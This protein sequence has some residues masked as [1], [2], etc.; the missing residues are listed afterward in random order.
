MI[1]AEWLDYDTTAEMADAVVGDVGFVIAAALETRGEALI[2]LPGG[3]SPAPILERLAAA[4]IDWRERDD[5]PYRRPPGPA[6]NS[7]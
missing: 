1:E 5:H 3:K 2:A 6:A 7:P 4:S